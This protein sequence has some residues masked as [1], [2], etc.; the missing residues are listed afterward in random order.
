MRHCSL[1]TD[2]NKPQPFDERAALEE[3]ERLAEKIQSTRRQRSQAVDEFDAFVR[4]FKH[5]RWAGPERRAPETP[6]RSQPVA[7]RQAV[8]PPP[9]IPTRPEPLE[10]DTPPAAPVVLAPSWKGV[11]TQPI[12]R[13][14]LAGV[15]VL[16]IVLLLWRPWSALPDQSAATSA[17]PTSAP[18]P[19][20]T[21]APAAAPPIAKPTR[22]VNLELVTL[23]PVWTR[24]VVDDRKEVERELPAGQRFTFGADRTITVRAGDAGG[25]RII[26]D[27]KDLGLLGKDG[28]IA[29]RTFTTAA[30]RSDAR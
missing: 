30:G 1:V 26:H 24:V 15:G 19:S 2:L 23:R 18:A 11:I 27:G 9:E 21:P 17:A 5:D 7:E 6:L 13:W 10:M 25:M 28:Q 29:S 14:T 8:L 4:G 12:A 20:S 3:L 22:A 16:A